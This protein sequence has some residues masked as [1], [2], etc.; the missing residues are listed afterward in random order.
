[1]RPKVVLIILLAGAAGLAGLFFLKQLMT[2]RPQP[3][4][5]PVAQSTLPIP[6]TSPAVPQASS[7][8]N[9]SP[10]TNHAAP[11]APVAIVPGIATGTNAVI[12]LDT[13]YI[14]QKTDRLQEL[15]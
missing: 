3:T 12:A 14:Q 9:I 15:E 10:V 6:L 5:A 11:A 7:F 1:M 8:T 13:D 2:S 4:T